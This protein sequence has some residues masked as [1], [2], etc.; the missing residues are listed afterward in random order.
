MLEEDEVGRDRRRVEIE[1]MQLDCSIFRHAHAWIRFEREESCSAPKARWRRWRHLGRTRSLPGS[2]V[3][4]V[5][6]NDQLNDIKL[7]RAIQETWGNWLTWN[8]EM[9]ML[10][11]KYIPPRKTPVRSA[12]PACAQNNPGSRFKFCH[13]RWER[14]WN[15]VR[16]VVTGWACMIWLAG[17]EW[18]EAG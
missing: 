3:S 9:V 17:V 1:A 14:H 5:Y 8:P 12:I 16:V 4:R 15:W 7:P 2:W 13:S 18:F 6:V 10:T 11:L